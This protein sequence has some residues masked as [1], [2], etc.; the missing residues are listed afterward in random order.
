MNRK[1]RLIVVAGLLAIGF[2]TSGY[3]GCD[4]GVLDGGP[5]L[6]D[7]VTPGDLCC[8]TARGGGSILIGDQS[9]VP[10]KA[11][12]GF[13]VTCKAD[14][15][16]NPVVTG[17]LE[18]QDHRP[19]TNPNIPNAVPVSVSFHGVAKDQGY[20]IGECTAKKGGFTGTY[21]PQPESLGEGGK[22]HVAVEDTGERGPSA[23]DTFTIAIETGVFAG[24]IQTGTLAG[25][26]IKAF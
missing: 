8:N 21:K 4:P 15:Q 20:V 24:Y 3:S 7:G 17:Q 6:P 11:T 9:S 23:G 10:H 12:F 1:Y 5:T 18:Y 25:G 14:A 22:F 16:G 2:L 19:W 26:N 13:Q